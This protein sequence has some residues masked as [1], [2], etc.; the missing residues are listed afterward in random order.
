MGSNATRAELIREG[1][2]LTLCHYNQHLGT[3]IGKK[4][5]DVNLC[6]EMDSS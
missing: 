4:N 2:I 1:N 5:L 6:I 3:V